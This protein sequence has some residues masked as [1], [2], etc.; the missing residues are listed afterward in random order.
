MR[1]PRPTKGQTHK[2]SSRNRILL[3]E[4]CTSLPDLQYVN[5]Y[6]WPIADFTGTP[7]HAS[8]GIFHWFSQTGT[9]P[10]LSPEMPCI[11]ASC[12]DITNPLP[13]APKTASIVRVS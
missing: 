8:V 9:I 5:M 11:E 13:R 7:G 4:G 2:E 12:G 10:P 1:V 3:G 6:T